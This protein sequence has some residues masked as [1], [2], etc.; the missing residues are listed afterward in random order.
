MPQS[1]GVNVA[2]R[3]GSIPQR[4]ASTLVYE[5][6][7]VDVEDRGDRD[8]NGRNQHFGATIT[9]AR[10]LG[11]GRKERPHSASIAIRFR[12]QGSIEIRDETEPL[13]SAG[14]GVELP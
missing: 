3:V 12:Y 5:I 4:A 7:K 8:G 6:A 14:R 13:L 2:H 9:A 1:V 11:H 10:M